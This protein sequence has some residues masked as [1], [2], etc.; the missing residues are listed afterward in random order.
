MRNIYIY[1]S[2][3]EVCSVGHITYMHVDI[4]CDTKST[5]AND[6]KQN[7]FQKVLIVYFTHLSVLL[8]YLARIMVVQNKG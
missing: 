3:I 1:A 7:S 4:E 6:L 5:C 8:I 2:E